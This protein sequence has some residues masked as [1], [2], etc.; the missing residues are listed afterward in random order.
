MP[1][2][3]EPQGRITAGTLAAALIGASAPILPG[4]AIGRLQLGLTM[5][6]RALFLSGGAVTGATHCWR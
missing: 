5:G 2:G 4:L 3:C 6:L 1:G